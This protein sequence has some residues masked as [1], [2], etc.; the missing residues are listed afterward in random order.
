M[1]RAGLPCASEIILEHH[2]PLNAVPNLIMPDGSQRIKRIV[3]VAVVM[4]RHT[5]VLPTGHGR[6]GGCV[7]PA[8]WKNF[9]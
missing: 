9:T 1:F 4:D 7:R 2:R 3:Y 8:G 5:F 6:H